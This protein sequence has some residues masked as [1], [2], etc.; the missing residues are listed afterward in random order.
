[1]KKRILSYGLVLVIAL[2]LSEAFHPLAA[3]RTLAQGDCIT[4][5]ETGQ[6][7]CGAFMAYWNER[8][9]LPVYGYPITGE[10]PEVSELD[11]KTYTVQYFERAVFEKHP[12]NKPPYDV[13][14][15]QLGTYLYNHRYRSTECCDALV[16]FDAQPSGTTFPLGG[17]YTEGSTNMK[18]V[19]FFWASGAPASPPGTA[20]IDNLG[21]SGGTGQDLSLNNIS[22]DFAFAGPVEKVTLNFGDMGGNENLTINGKLLNVPDLSAVNGMNVAGVQITVVILISSGWTKLGQLTLEGPI[23]QLSIGG[24]E[25]WIDNVC[26]HFEKK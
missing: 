15:S 21:K 1:M 19:D 25:F 5:K 13:L 20:K 18:F 16:A 14:L 6:T 7:A 9:A 2:A 23:S 26:A 8:G 11:G 24:Q 17:T 3:L 10:F 4:F 12:E 22:I